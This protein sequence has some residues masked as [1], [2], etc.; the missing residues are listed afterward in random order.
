MSIYRGMDIGTAKP[1]PAAPRRPPPL[2]RRARAARG[3]QR[4][5]ICG[6]GW[7]Q[8]P[9]KSSREAKRPCLSAERDFT[10]AVFCEACSKGR[11]PIL[12]YVASLRP[13]AL[14]LSADECTRVES[15]RSVRG[16]QDS[17]TR[18]PPHRPCL[19]GSRPHGP[20][21]VGT[22]T[23]GPPAPR[24]AAETRR[25]ALAPALGFMTASIGAS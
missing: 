6:G 8:R 10:F 2:D 17:S 13:M 18:R 4:C 16:R 19:G 9:R 14:R 23:S 7:R 25:L 21:P 1:S 22:A 3:V 11:R 15:R 24:R 12:S 5:A 20:A